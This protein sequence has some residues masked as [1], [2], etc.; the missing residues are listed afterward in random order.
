MASI[1]D[2][3]FIMFSPLQPAILAADAGTTVY[4]ATAAIAAAPSNF[5]IMLLSFA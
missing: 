4:A 3:V 1:I 2:S 5:L